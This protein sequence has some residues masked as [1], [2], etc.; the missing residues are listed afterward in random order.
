M[1]GKV[2]QKE[3]L[4]IYFSKLCLN[5]TSLIDLQQG[6][7]VFLYLSFGIIIIIFNYQFII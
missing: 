4:S 7:E 2:L 6:N 3:Q 5:L 1:Y